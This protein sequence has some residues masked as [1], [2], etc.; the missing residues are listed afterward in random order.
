M[1]RKFAI[2]VSICHQPYTISR[3][4]IGDCFFTLPV[5]EAQEL[6]SKSTDRIDQNVTKLESSLGR[7]RDEMQELKVALY[8]RF[9]RS[10]N[11]EI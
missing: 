11:L 4:K 10:I 3:Y 5:S 2:L 8:S 6:I 1:C 9:G 7:V